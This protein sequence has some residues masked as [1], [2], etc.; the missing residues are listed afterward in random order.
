MERVL[1]G[2]KPVGTVVTSGKFT[3]VHARV[4]RKA[5]QRLGLQCEVVKTPGGLEQAYIFQPG[6][7]LREYYAGQE[8]FV[9]AY[10]SRG[11][12]LP[13]GVFDAPIQQLVHG[14]EDSLPVAGLC[15]GYPLHETLK[16]LREQ[17]FSARA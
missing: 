17:R 10:A 2:K 4:L 6:R 5:C 13:P 9:E 15:L 12:E 8:V 11:V 7:T 16:L 3:K 1:S 14:M